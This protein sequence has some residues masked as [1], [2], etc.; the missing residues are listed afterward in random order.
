[1]IFRLSLPGPRTTQDGE[2][3]RQAQTA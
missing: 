2:L 1:K 3:P